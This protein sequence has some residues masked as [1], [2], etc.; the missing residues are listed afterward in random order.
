M[1][2]LPLITLIYDHSFWKKMY[3][4]WKNNKWNYNAI[5]YFWIPC[6]FL[7]LAG[8]NKLFN[9]HE[10][11]SLRDLYSSFM[12]LPFLLITARG[13]FS[14]RVFKVAVIFVIIEC[15]VGILEYYFK[16]R[17]FF[18]PLNNESMIF[19][20]ISIYGTR[21][22]GF[23]TNSPIFGLRCLIALFILEFIPWK[24]YLKWIFKVI[25]FLGVIVSFNRSVVICCLV[26]YSLQFVQLAWNQRHSLRQLVRNKYFYDSLV[27]FI[28]LAL[29]FGSDFMMKGMNRD[30]VKREELL[31]QLNTTEKEKKFFDGNSENGLNTEY[32]NDSSSVQSNNDVSVEN[33]SDTSS[34][35]KQINAQK[36]SLSILHYP[37]LKEI[38]ELD[39]LGAFTRNFLALTES[40]QSSGRK[41]IWLNYIQFIEKN[42]LVGNGSEKLYFTAL[43][44][45]NNELELMHAHNSFLELFAT[46]GLLL[47]LMYLLMIG[48][49]WQ[50]KNS[51]FIITILIYSMM[52]YGIFWGM[53]FIDVIFVFLIISNY[54]NVNFGSKPSRS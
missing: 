7:F 37:Q 30:G 19:N 43:N 1:L 14:I 41:L 42:P 32:S 44:P 11:R 31:V 25:L 26:F 23:A 35:L 40:I 13:I 12:L 2:A 15:F 34:S 5:R 46:N 20:D 9:G 36:N 51:P 48:M 4:N 52:Q 22:F 29:V 24:R 17:S 53:S 3:V 45:R 54:N 39:S 27:T 6:L 47:G 18:V 33:R 49:W 10:L 50:K 16:T 21:V 38:Y 8:L 28:L